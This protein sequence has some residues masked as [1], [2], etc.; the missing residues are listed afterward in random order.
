M[1][2]GLWK[3]ESQVPRAAL[4]PMGQ[5][6]ADQTGIAGTVETQEEMERRYALDL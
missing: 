4:P 2:S 5:M 6:I 3:A 1:R